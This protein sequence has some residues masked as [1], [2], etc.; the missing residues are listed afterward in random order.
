[1]DNNEILAKDC[2]DAIQKVN[3]NGKFQKLALFILTICYTCT[4]AFIVN[5]FVFLEKDPPFICFNKDKDEAI[6][7]FTCSRKEVCGDK[8]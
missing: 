8:Y 5:A 3:P 6:S 4:G 7:S 1:M 2:E